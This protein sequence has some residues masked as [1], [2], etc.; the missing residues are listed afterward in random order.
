MITLYIIHPTLYLA[1]REMV[2]GMID[3]DTAGPN[4]VDWDT[5]LPL[6]GTT[7]HSISVMAR[8]ETPPHRDSGTCSK[9]FDFLVSIGHYDVAW[10]HLS[11]LR[12]QFAVTP[13]TL[14]AFSG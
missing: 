10:L 6:W 12:T 8:R 9:W 13:G 7:F 5:L 14:C 3:K 4:S 11:N 2:F 1:S